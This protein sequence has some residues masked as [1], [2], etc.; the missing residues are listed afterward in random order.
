MHFFFLKKLVISVKVQ[1]LIKEIS[2]IF[3][4][5]IGGFWCVKIGHGHKK[6]TSGAN[7]HWD[8]AGNNIILGG[9]IPRSTIVFGEKYSYYG[10]TVYNFFLQNLLIFSI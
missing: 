2:N 9:F 4:I 6:M 1:K 10:F 8:T 3:A 7:Y 5:K